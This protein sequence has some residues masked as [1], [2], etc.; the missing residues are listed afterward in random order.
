MPLTVTYLG[1][2]GFLFSDGVHTVAIDPFLT[3]N[4]VAKHTPEQID[5]EAIIL[6]HGHEDHYGDTTAIAQR[7]GAAVHGAYEL[8]GF[9]QEQGVKNIEPMNPGG[10]L[11]TPW[12]WV[13]LTHAFHSSSHGGRYLGM[14]CGVIL[15]LGGT[16]IY[17]TGDTGIFSD[18]KLFGEIYRPDL[19]C[20]PI[21]DRFTMG[22]ELASRAAEL[23]GAKWAIPT[24]YNTWPPIAQDPAAFQPRGVEVRVMEPGSSWNMPSDYD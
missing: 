17:H 21:G 10:R 18:M 2:S 8:C 4:P 24:H 15:H 12:G 7:T 23:I 20:I 16:T 19:A 1:H 14:P 11:V 6:T 22:P 9:A 5:C 13:A 3:G